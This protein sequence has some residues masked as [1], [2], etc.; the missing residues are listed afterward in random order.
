MVQSRETARASLWAVAAGLRRHAGR[1][2]RC[3]RHL[4]DAARQAA[5]Q[6]RRARKI[7]STFQWTRGRSSPKTCRKL[8]EI[9]PNNIKELQPLPKS[10]RDTNATSG[11]RFVRGAVCAE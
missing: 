4:Q 9:T 11:T 5:A 7:I 6:T 8:F 2:G 1:A 10:T 3:L